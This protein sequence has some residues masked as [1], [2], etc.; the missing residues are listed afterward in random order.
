MASKGGHWNDLFVLLNHYAVTELSN[1]TV[2]S[3][4]LGLNS[5]IWLVR[6]AKEHMLGVHKL[7]IHTERPFALGRP[8]HINHVKENLCSHLDKNNT[9]A[10]FA[11]YGRITHWT[12]PTVLTHNKIK[13]LD[14]DRIQYISE[15][16]LQITDIKEKIITIL[17]CNQVVLYVYQRS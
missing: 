5:I 15:K 14:S 2:A 17:T 13:L 6:V 10:L 7:H 16:T 8:N 1:L 12:V 11:L 9:S 4:G 3:T